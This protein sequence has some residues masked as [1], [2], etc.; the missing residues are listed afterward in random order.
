LSGVVCIP[1]SVEVLS[2]RQDRRLRP[3]RALTFGSDSRLRH[4]SATG[5]RLGSRSFVQVTGRSLKIFRMDREF[6][7]SA[8]DPTFCDPTN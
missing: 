4:F 2:F 1:D 3:Q 6:E 5:R 7:G 8:F